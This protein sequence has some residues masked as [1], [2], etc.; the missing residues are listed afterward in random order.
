MD[1][2]MQI[3]KAHNLMVIEDACQAPLSVYKGKKVGTIGELGCISFQAS[4]AISCGEGGIIIGNDQKLMDECFTVHNR[5]TDKQGQN[6]TIGTKYRMN[7]FE[8]AIL[9]GQLPG[10]V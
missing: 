10:A 8:G 6:A 3:A 1:R 2:I 7:E 9:L 5:G 4:K